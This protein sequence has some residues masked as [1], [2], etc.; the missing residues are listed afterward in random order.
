MLPEHADIAVATAE[1]EQLLHRALDLR[2]IRV[3][4]LSG[5]DVMGALVLHPDCR[6]AEVVST[7]SGRIGKSCLTCHR[8]FARHGF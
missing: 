8:A 4:H 6:V 2:T 1:Y 5:E 3:L 7:V